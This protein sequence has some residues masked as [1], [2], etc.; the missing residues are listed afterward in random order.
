MRSIR[1]ITV[2][3]VIFL[4]A[5]SCN[6]NNE[7]TTPADYLSRDDTDTKILREYKTWVVSEA[8]VEIPNKP[9]LVYKKGQP[10]QGNFDPS[11]ISFVF[12]SNSTYQG[13]DEKGRPETGVWQL[14]TDA[15]KLSINASNEK[16]T[17]NIVQLTKT[18]LDIANTESYDENNLATVTIKMVPNR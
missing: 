9:T 14:S 4:V 13:T 11:K 15:K 3:L 18:N 2:I 16:S 12:S 10:I 5:V 17:Y 6:K 8:T 7:I 1:T